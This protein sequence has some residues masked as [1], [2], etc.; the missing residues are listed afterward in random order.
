MEFNMA[1]HLHSTGLVKSHL[2]SSS[3]LFCHSLAEYSSMLL[4]GE[5]TI[6]ASSLMVFAIPRLSLE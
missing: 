4:G 2:L 3:M 6:Q 5:S 1:V